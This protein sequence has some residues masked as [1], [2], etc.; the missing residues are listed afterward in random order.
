MAAIPTPPWTPSTEF[1]RLLFVGHLTDFKYPV[2]FSQ[3]SYKNFI[4]F[5]DLESNL[6]TDL[7]VV[8]IGFLEFLSQSFLQI[9]Q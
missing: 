4:Y 6:L 2:F 5:K 1:A 9:S 3:C 8:Q 7:K